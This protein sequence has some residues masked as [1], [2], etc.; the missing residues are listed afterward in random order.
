MLASNIKT[1]ATRYGEMAY[2]ASDVYI[3]RSL[4]L[5]GEYSQAE[6]DLFAT[7]ISPGDNVIDVGANI[8]A[9]TAA[10]AALVH[11][12]GRVFAFE[13]QPDNYA[14]LMRNCEQFPAVVRPYAIA[15][16]K[17][18][19]T[20]K[21]PY[22]SELTFK[23]YGGIAIGSGEA[24]V[25]VDTLDHVLDA[26]AADRIAFIKIDV[27]GCERDVVLGARELI[28]RSRP[29]LYLEEHPGG[30]DGLRVL[31]RSLDYVLFHHRPA[32]WGPDNFKGH[33]DNVFGNI[34]SFN[35]LALPKEK[36]FVDVTGDL[37]PIE[38]SA[39]KTG[40]A[41]IARFGGVG[42]NLIAAAGLR[43][44]HAAGY[45]VEMISQAP[46]AVLFE[47]NPFVDKLSV[48][49]KGDLPSDQAA[50]LAWFNLR[51]K[52]YA[53]FLNL[54][55][56]I[57]SRHAAFP[58]MTSFWWPAHYRRKLFA[59]SYIETV[60]ELL[61]L[62]PVFGPLF[63]PTEAEKQQALATRRAL[64]D[65]P[66]IGWCMSG[67][68]LDKV[69]PQAPMVIARLIKELGAQVVMLAAPPPYRDFELCKQALDMVT[70]Q[71]GSAAGLLHAGSPSMDNQTWPIRRILTFAM[72]CD[73]MIGPD[74]GPMWGVAFEPLPKILL[75]SH[76]SVE[77]I[78]KHWVNTTSLCA[79]P[80]RV[81]CWPCHRLHDEGSTCRPNA[82]N[83]GAACISDISADTIVASATVLLEGKRRAA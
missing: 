13:P 47:N 14:L 83:N 10:L 60:F 27:E 28:K 7:L 49:E 53:H 6:V 35:I 39:C 11:P 25:R 46:Q 26:G 63:F 70:A 40:W 77:N 2:Y 76:A 64:G 69:Y 3:G 4:E 21:M 75:H 33:H 15:L 23:N 66:I 19:G 79:D 42:D 22:L 71:N 16:G 9:L 48:Y 73:L 62:P 80:R 78:T 43:A 8:G 52:E 58:G 36:D 41:A 30:D 24:T 65:G 12:R 81:D 20:A 38:V 5:Y 45:K 37:V 51:S 55:H 18:A 74:T 29:V 50:W 68:R 31:L 59:G 72:G 82:W 67:T 1:T 17:R 56:S 34:V 61:D 54:S 32:L 44:L 57:E